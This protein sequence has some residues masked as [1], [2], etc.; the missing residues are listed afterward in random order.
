MSSHDETG[1]PFSIS[2]DQQNFR[3]IELP[4]ALLELIASENAPSLY[5][6]SEQ[7]NLVA[8][9]TPAPTAVIC[10]HDQTFEVRQVQSSNILYIIEPS[11]IDSGDEIECPMLSGVT[12][13]GQCKA[14]LELVPVQTRPVQFLRHAIPIY[15]EKKFLPLTAGWTGGTKSKQALLADA[16]FSTS[17]FDSAWTELC[18]FEI[19][20]EAWRPS[21][22]QLDQIWSSFMAETTIR[23]IDV[24]STF[25]YVDRILTVVEDG[26]DKAI[27]HAILRMLS[28]D[29]EHTMEGWVLIDRF[30]CVQ[31]V[32]QVY[33]EAL[34]RGGKAAPSNFLQIWQDQLPERWREDAKLDLLSASS[35]DLGNGR[36]T[37]R[38][39]PSTTT[40][41]VP[42][43]KASG[44]KNLKPP[45]LDIECLYAS[46]EDLL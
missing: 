32:G 45:G 39:Q 40:K 22:S 30:K 9:S 35:T 7:P 6:K 20:D 46:N 5:L 41:Q 37:F 8:S 23:G 25:Q 31:W 15:N 17:E 14:L 29:D 38:G 1:V 16:P 12:A 21:A 27:P 13:F 2:N 43:A 10:T 19:E 11:S 3:L 42:E 28:S 33:L 4:P 44:M 34:C 26:W 18:A 24:T 36:I